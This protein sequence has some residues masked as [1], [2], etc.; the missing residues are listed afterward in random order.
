VSSLQ[1]RSP[2]GTTLLISW[3]PPTTP[4]GAILN[5]SISI[6]L[7]D[8]SVVRQET[9]LDTLLIETDLGEKNNSEMKHENLQVLDICLTFRCNSFINLDMH[10]NAFTD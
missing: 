5:Y 1:A 2:N 9:I 10:A 4:N 6:N 3:E 8:G 7:L